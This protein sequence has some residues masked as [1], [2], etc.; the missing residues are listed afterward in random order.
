MNKADNPAITKE[1]MI[2]LVYA[3]LLIV[4]LL[5]LS[6]NRI[7]PHTMNTIDKNIAII[8]TCIYNR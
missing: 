1:I 8:T 4:F 5:F 3:F 2:H 7:I 6:N